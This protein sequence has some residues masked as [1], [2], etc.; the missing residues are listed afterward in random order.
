MA[1]TK[2]QDKKVPLVIK[3]LGIFLAGLIGAISGVYSYSI[4]GSQYLVVRSAILFVTG[5]MSFVL[6]YG[7]WKGSKW[8]WWFGV[9]ISLA[10]VFATLI[11]YNV[12][13]LFIGLLLFCGLTQGKTRTYFHL[14]AQSAIE[15][16]VSYSWAIILICI[17]VALIYV[18]ILPAPAQVVPNNCRFSDGV[19]CTDIEVFNTSQSPNTIT[20]AALL[21]NSNNYPIVSPMVYASYAGQNTSA[22]DCTPGGTV[23]AGES[24]LCIGSLPTHGSIGQLVGANLYLSTQACSTP[25]CSLS[26]S[27]TYTGSFTTH[28]QPPPSPLSIGF[29]FTA[30]S[31]NPTVYNNDS[32]MATL[33]L[34]GLPLKNAAV[35]FT[36]N[37]SKYVI[38]NVTTT[39]VN[40]NASAT[41]YSTTPGNVAVT[42][43]YLDISN[44]LVI[45]YNATTSTSVTTTT[46]PTT[47]TPTLKLVEAPNDAANYWTLC[48]NY[49]S[50]GVAQ[51][52]ECVGNLNGWS[53]TSNTFS[54]P[55][56]TIINTVCVADVIP[57]YYSFTG[58]S[59]TYSSQLTSNCGSAYSINVVGNANIHANYNVITNNALPVANLIL[60]E[61]PAAASNYWSLC[62]DYTYP[63]YS[64]GMPQEC[65]GDYDSWTGSTNTLTVP[66][67]TVIQ[68]ICTTDRHGGN[69]SFDSYTGNFASQITKGACGYNYDIVVTGR[70]LLQANYNGTTNPTTSSTTSTSTTATTTIG[71]TIYY[72]LVMRCSG[73]VYSN[74]GISP[75]GGL[76]YTDAAGSHAHIVA[77]STTTSTSSCTSGEAQFAGWVGTGGGYTGSSTS[78]N[79]VINNNIQE[80]ATYN[81]SI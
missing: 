69:Y 81:C 8:S 33:S 60:N 50:S 11:S 61:S 67:N 18:Y 36:T 30:Q 57:G 45:D 29:K 49:T 20:F 65:V 28:V 58:Y 56:N 68:T 17:A 55:F 19:Y 42:A 44:T 7:L 59:G 22:F 52:Q 40:G 76:Q 79:I 10:L 34:F 13:D 54:V 63:G 75:E 80:N 16:L 43:T 51:P 27:E 26:L 53:S 14:E 23:A 46:Q 48:V 47:V 24:T 77:P 73:P 25:T 21:V 72:T 9:L 37:N 66:V 71:K 5:I 74:C 6:A 62:V 15:Y 64:G 70:S 31:Y 3:I 12:T 41:L 38:S 2:K 39:G 1:K 4:I 35:N 78:A 32:L